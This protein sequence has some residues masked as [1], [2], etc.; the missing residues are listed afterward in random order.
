MSKKSYVFCPGFSDGYD[1]DIQLEDINE[2][3]EYVM[4]NDVEYFAILDAL[5][6][7]YYGSIEVH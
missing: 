5:S 6:L 1:T 3:L 7:E 4:K 2:V